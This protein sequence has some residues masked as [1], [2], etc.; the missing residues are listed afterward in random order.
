MKTRIFFISIFLSGIFFV[1]DVFAASQSS[2]I[3]KNIEKVDPFEVIM[4]I[5]EDATIDVNEKIV[6][7]YDGEM[8]TG[9]TRY[10]PLVYKDL[11]GKEFN[12][13]V[14]KVTVK[15]ENGN[16]YEFKKTNQLSDEQE[17]S[18]ERVKNYAKIRIGSE[19]QDALGVKTYIIDYKLSGAINF[20]KDRDQLFWNIAGDRWSVPVKHPSVRI[21][22]PKEIK[23]RDVKKDCF[24]GIYANTTKCIDRA[25][26]KSLG[27]AYYSYKGLIERQGMTVTFNFPKG[28]VNEPSIPLSLFEK[29]KDYFLDNWILISSILAVLII[30]SV[31]EVVYFKTLKKLYLLNKRFIL[32][33]K[34]KKEQN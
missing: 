25:E 28:I 22:L 19:N 31:L 5:N 33:L 32:S 13:R 21:Y 10:I 34:N 18:K 16:P 17:G 24:I 26:K 27:A 30:L 12:V 1:S 8:K 7:D 4:R 9:F 11:T 3:S 29:A 14:S 6:Y 2:L 23:K 15:D 20:L